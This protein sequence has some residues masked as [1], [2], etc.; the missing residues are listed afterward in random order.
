MRKLIAA[1]LL[2][3][4]SSTLAE[5]AGALVP[6]TNT[7]YGSTNSR[8]IL[9]TDGTS[10][11]LFSRSGGIVTVTRLVEG[12]NRAGELLFESWRPVDAVWTGTHFLV[13]TEVFEGNSS[14]LLGRLVD[15]E[16]HPVGGPFL[17]QAD[18]YQPRLA[19]G[20]GAVLLV[21][22]NSRNEPR[23]VLLTPDGRTALHTTP[24]AGP[25]SENAV[26]AT[27]SGFIAITSTSTSTNA[28]R[29]DPQGRIIA[30]QPVSGPYAF[31]AAAATHGSQSLL[32]WCMSHRVEVALLRDDGTL[33]APLTLDTGS[34]AEP[35]YP[36]APS[37]TWNGSGWTVAYDGYSPA[38]RRVNVVHLDAG[39]GRV[40]S[41][42]KNSAWSEEPSVASIGS[43]VYAA[44]TPSNGTTV[45]S[46]LPLSTGAPRPATFGAATQ[47]LHLAA[48]SANALLVIWAEGTGEQGTLHAGTRTHDGQWSEHELGLD[49]G[50]EAGIA[51]DTRNFVL[52]FSSQTETTA[53]F[54]DEEGRTTGLRTL[55]PFRPAVAAWNGHHY[56]LV[57]S[58]GNAVLL[59][60]DG[61][62]S[63]PVKLNLGFGPL[64]IASNGDG[65]LL[66]GG[67]L[68]CR[69]IACDPVD[70]RAI[71]LTAALEPAGAEIA[72]ETSDS[73]PGAVVWNGSHYVVLWTSAKG[74]GFTRIAPDSDT[75]TTRQIP[76]LTGIYSAAPAGEGRLAILDRRGEQ[77]YVRFYHPDGTLLDTVA[78]D[79]DRMGFVYQKLV[80][81]AGGAVAYLTT[82]LQPGA[83]HYGATRLAMAIVGGPPIAPP[84]AP[85]VTVRDEGVRFIVEWTA[86]AGTVNGYRLEYRVD[87][88]VWIEL[89]RWFGPADQSVSVRRPSFGSDFAFR[90]RAFNDGGASAYSSAAA[91]A[92][93]KKRRAVR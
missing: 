24:L 43:R 11:F 22:K 34:E 38:G 36:Q 83:P 86:P 71:R 27:P 67:R 59:A 16:G 14:V 91:P 48:S 82:S 54:L 40:L 66:A 6:L 85:R 93:P 15:R 17:L 35:L 68:Q 49:L 65:F 8:S 19:A 2:L 3:L 69:F 81:L 13:A 56:A 58:E 73:Y 53:F 4:A 70:V 61:T 26:T 37:A 57:D 79:E 1:V 44:W 74:T 46:T 25:Y 76:D 92:V 20:H 9:R 88:G 39:A 63:T 32:V 72:I 23:A 29:L 41:H 33:G 51:S 84:A 78:L 89:E 12:Q 87:N 60:P 75:A 47:G 50:F 18:A 52:F 62:L 64:Y 31:H 45:V 42:E 28:T 7:R 21:C 10:A 77:R 80:P 55:L 5:T 90:V 30:S